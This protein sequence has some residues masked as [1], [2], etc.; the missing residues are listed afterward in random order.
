MK[1]AMFSSKAYDR[2][3]F[4]R[5]NQKLGY[6]WTYLDNHLTLES[7]PLAA[8]F[9]AICVFVNDRL[10]APVLEKLAAQGTHLI[11]LRC[12]GFNNVD[13][14]VADSLGIK[15]VRVPAYSPFSVAEHAV[16]LILTL[17]RKIHRAHNRVREG[18]FSLQGLL[19]FD[20]NGKTVGIIGTGQIGLMFAKIMQGFGCR[21]LGYDP[22]PN[23]ACEALGMNYVPLPELYAQADVISIHCPLT[24][25]TK[26]LIN[27]TA[28][29]QMK[30]GV[31]IIN[32]SRGAVV[33]TRDVIT[34]LKSGRIGSLGLDVYEEEANYFFEDFSEGVINDD[35]LARLLTF[36]NVIVTGHQA[37]FTHEALTSIAETTLNN[38]HDIETTNE[39]SNSVTNIKR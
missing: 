34:G 19:G 17:N 4:D 1:I 28:I 39:C 22:Y 11:A 3:F 26:H 7:V 20:L 18:N 27:A 8:N 14:A 23:P 33:N 29:E 5:A 12:A 6:E 31:M 30:R 15:V 37:F 24:P 32:T 38:I 25:D 9:P 13:V 2:F 35:V 10:D 36:S 21:L 16:A